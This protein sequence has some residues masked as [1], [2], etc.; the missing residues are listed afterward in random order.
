MRSSVSRWLR[1]GPMLL[2]VAGAAHGA[3]AMSPADML[4]LA[5]GTTFEVVLPKVEPAH[6]KYEKALPLELLSFTERNDKYWSVGTAFAIGDNQY[7]SAAHVL[8]SGIG[9]AMGKP[10]LRSATGEVYPVTRILK[11]SVDEDFIVFSV[12]AAPAVQPLVVNTQSAIGAPVFAVGNALG[13]GVVIRDGLLTSETAEDQ[14]GR[15]KW[16]RFSAAASPGNSGGPLL[17]AAGQVIGVITAKSPGENLNFA[18]P[19]ARVLQGKDDVSVANVRSSFGLPILRGEQVATFGGQF[20]LPADWD[21]FTAAM[22]RRQHRNYSDAQR[23]LLKQEKDSLP[24]RGESARLA[25]TLDPS[26]QYALLKQG[27]DNSW[28]LEEGESDEKAELPNDGEV[29]IRSVSGMSLFR[30]RRSLKQS[31]PNF[32]RDGAAMMD[33][34]LRGI[35]LPRYVGTQAIRITSLGSP[36]TDVVLRDRFGRVWQERIW[37]IGYSDLQ[38]VSMA[39]PTP[40]GYVGQLSFANASSVQSIR[41]KLQL[42]ADYVHLSYSGS[43]QQ[44]RTFLDQKDLAPKMLRDTALRND[45]IEGLDLRLPSLSMR[46][47]RSVIKM[48]DSSEI[49][50]YMAFLPEGDSLTWEPLGALAEEKPDDSSFVQ[51]LGQP[52]PGAGA[53]TKL[54]ERWAKLVARDGEYTGAPRN[55]SQFDQF[56]TRGV[57]GDPAAERLFEVVMNLKEKSLLPR[58]VIERR[59]QLL[60]GI[61]TSA[62]GR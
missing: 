14:D 55:S 10:A 3:D 38:I 58:Q 59:D 5:G 22:L 51:V 24:P 50:L 1:A 7:V 13:D 20:P 28:A 17:D 33:L 34:L 40:D 36:Q 19:M 18:L 49:S 31:D 57:V 47:P 29:E 56:W 39:L 61:K 60:T 12:Q 27:D 4:K 62:G 52:K 48:E 30:L 44:W 15:W 21:T 25:A 2:Y 11:H 23:D 41:E 53:G 54:N 16:L 46:I 8:H 9:S 42:T 45:S 35:K 43:V 32:Y 37:Q 6:V 26:V